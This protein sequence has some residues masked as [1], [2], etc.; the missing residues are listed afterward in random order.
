MQSLEKVEEFTCDPIPKK[1]AKA[2]EKK[3]ESYALK[4]P[5]MDALANT[6]IKDILE[7]KP[8][9]IDVVNQ[10]TGEITEAEELPSHATMLSAAKT[11]KAR[12]EPA[13]K[14]GFNLNMKGEVAP[15]DLSR[16]RLRERPAPSV[17]ADVVEEKAEESVEDSSVVES[18]AHG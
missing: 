1:S 7:A 10:K 12:S 15:V 17:E 13:V 18:G 3:F 16:Y 8:R 5:E 4:S 9:T 2:L 11:V 14:V 6:V